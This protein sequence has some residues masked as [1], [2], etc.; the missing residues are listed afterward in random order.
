MFEHFEFL[1]LTQLGKVFDVSAIQIGRWLVKIGPFHIRACPF[2]R[3]APWA[4][5]SR[6]FGPKK[7]QQFLPDRWFTSS[8]TFHHASDGGES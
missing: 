4:I 3:A 8:A 6:P 2:P 7:S 1:S 5:E